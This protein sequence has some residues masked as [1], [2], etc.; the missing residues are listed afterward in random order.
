MAG[1]G[2]PG[3]AVYGASDRFAAYPTRNAVTP[4]QI[5]A[6]IFYTLG[7]DPSTEIYDPFEN[8]K[9]PIALGAPIQG[10]FA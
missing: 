7:V 10:L 3:G 8:R 2:I 6:T 1:G 4:E 5:T 9:K